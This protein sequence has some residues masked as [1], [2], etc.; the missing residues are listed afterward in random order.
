MTEPTEQQDKE[1][2]GG[3]DERIRTWVLFAAGLIILFK[4]AF[5][6]PKVIDPALTFLVVGCLFGKGLLNIW[7]GDK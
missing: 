2:P 6:S 4:F 1:T 5:A 7:R 3:G